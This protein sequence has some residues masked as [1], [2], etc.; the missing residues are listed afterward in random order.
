MWLH[1]RE[2]VASTSP[3]MAISGSDSES[4]SSS[5]SE[6]SC[7]ACE[8]T[9]DRQLL[10]MLPPI[11]AAG[12]EYDML[13]SRVSSPRTRPCSEACEDEDLKLMSD[14]DAIPTLFS[15]QA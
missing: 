6:D 1:L 7:K 3:S 10:R 9:L 5:P 8:S 13:S 2:R 4:S 11:M 12:K 14:P 15:A